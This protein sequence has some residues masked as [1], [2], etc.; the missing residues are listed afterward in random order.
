MKSMSRGR[1]WPSSP[2]LAWRWMFLKVPYLRRGQPPEQAIQKPPSG[3]HQIASRIIGA[4]LHR[5]RSLQGREPE[6]AQRAEHGS[7]ALASDR[8]IIAQTIRIDHGRGA[9]SATG[10]FGR[11]RPRLLIRQDAHRCQPSSLP[12]PP[13]RT[14]HTLRNL[15][16]Q[17][18]IRHAYC[19]HAACDGGAPTRHVTVMLADSSAA[20]DA[21]L[22]SARGLKATSRIPP[23]CD[24]TFFRNT[25]QANQSLGRR[26][27]H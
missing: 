20:Y 8:R 19:S 4:E 9:A 12:A 1:S 24:N 13:P 16:P 14:Q 21:I 3:P 22:G 27:I 11:E 15:V 25:S 10:K 7:A 26:P 6:L 18:S 17:C 23:D 5:R 2:A